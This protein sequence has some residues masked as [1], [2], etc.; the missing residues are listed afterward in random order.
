MQI[1]AN[2]ESSFINN[3]IEDYEEEFIALIFL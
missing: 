2:S 3:Y 1:F